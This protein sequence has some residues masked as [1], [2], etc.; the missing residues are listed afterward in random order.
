MWSFEPVPGYPN[1][2]RFSIALAEPDI[3]VVTCAGDDDPGEIHEKAGLTED[4]EQEITVYGLL[5]GADY[6]CSLSAGAKQAAVLSLRTDPLP[7]WV[8]AF[9]TSG[10]PTDGGYTLTS[11]G[12]DTP[13]EREAKLLVID[14]D[15][16]VR[17]ALPAVPSSSTDLD[18]GLVDRETILYGG[19]F[20]APPTVA[21]LDGTLL[22]TAIPPSSGLRYHHHA[23]RMPDGTVLTLSEA[24]NAAPDGTS[25][26]GFS[27]ERLDESLQSRVWTW[28][29]QRAYDEG[30][31]PGRTPSEDLDIY[32]ANALFD[33]GNSLYISLR[34]RSQIV[35]IDSSTGD[36]VS[37]VGLGGDYTLIDEDGSLA[38]VT[39]WFY[40]QHAP[41]IDGDRVLMHDNGYYRASNLQTRILEL[42]LDRTAMTAQITW[43]YTEEGW[44]EPIWGDADWLASGNVLA[45]RAHCGHC[46]DPAAPER[47]ELIEIDPGTNEVVWRLTMADPMDSG[48]RSQRIDGCAI[49]NNRKYCPGS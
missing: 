5:A 17:A 12:K 21:R 36:Y 13:P 1:V 49:F 39:D 2:V 14:A 34:A 11:H 24:P 28:N 37:T 8:P 6:T 9:T 25:W 47:T 16:R 4:L 38:P 48:Y 43:S 42:K 32:H 44:Y 46:F 18:A 29:S 23:E 3:P 35:E 19:G 22:A 40:G 26:T 30:W 31:L 45:T 41:K 15:G 33:A 7:A 20:A 10:R 27:I